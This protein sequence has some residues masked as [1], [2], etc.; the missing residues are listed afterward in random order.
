[1]KPLSATSIRLFPY[2]ARRGARA[3][4]RYLLLT[5]SIV[6]AAFVTRGMERSLMG[7]MLPHGKIARVLLRSIKNW[8]EIL[9]SIL[10]SCIL[11]L[12]TD[13]NGT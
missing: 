8:I 13:D 12:Y 1:M 6:A 5:D 9:L 3:I 7:D 10:I 2:F 11:I 4:D